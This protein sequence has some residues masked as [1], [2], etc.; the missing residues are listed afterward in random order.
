GSELATPAESF[1]EGMFRVGAAQ[2]TALERLMDACRKDWT[3]RKSFRLPAAGARALAPRGHRRVAAQ[4]R[5]P[6]Q[7]SAL[8]ALAL[9]RQAPRGDRV[10]LAAR[11]RRA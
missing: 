7:R 3:P 2:V 4:V 9:G 5:Q 10:S 1:Y 8:R 6:A 11:A